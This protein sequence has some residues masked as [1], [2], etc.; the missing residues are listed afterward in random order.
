MMEQVQVIQNFNELFKEYHQRSFLFARSLVHINEVA[1]DIASEALIVL[2]E[3][4]NVEIVQSPKSFLFRVVKNKALDYLKHQKVLKR[5][6]ESIDEWNGKQLQQ[7]MNTLDKRDEEVLFSKEIKEIAA[8]TLECLP[9]KTREVFVL[10]RH[11]H[12][13][14]KK[15][16]EELGI[17]VKGVEYHITKA[18][19]VMTVNLKD[20]IT[21][22]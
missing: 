16:A 20:Y 15:I 17:T 4:M 18:L 7:H 22:V 19:K 9:K 11:Q 5:F 8:K 2:W 3:R 1:E 13:C 12:L 21:K 10:S 6:V 14:G